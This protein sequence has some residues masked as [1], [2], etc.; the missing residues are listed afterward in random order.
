LCSRG[1]GYA[2]D[3]CAPPQFELG[4]QVRVKN[5]HPVGHTRAPRYVRGKRGSI[6]RKHG[7]H[8]LPDS[9]AHFQGERPESLYGVRFEARELWGDAGN[10]R[11]GVYVDL[12]ESY[13]EPA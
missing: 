13:L 3:A 6:V 4:A 1:R 9:N 11:D 8:V 7:A 12:W 5:F 10:P 2:R